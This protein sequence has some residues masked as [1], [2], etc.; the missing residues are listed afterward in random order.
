MTAITVAATTVIAGSTQ[1]SDIVTRAL[2]RLQAIDIN[3]TPSAS[4]QSNALTALQEMLNAFDPMGVSSD[5]FTR[6]CVITDDS[7]IIEITAEAD[8]KRPT[9]PI[10]I[11]HN[12]SGTGIPSSSYVVEVQGPTLFRINADATADGAAVTVTFALLPFAEKFRGAITAM[13]AMRLAPDM[14][15]PDAPAQVIREATE[16]WDALLAAYFPNRYSE[17]EKAI[18]QRTYESFDGTALP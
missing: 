4:E 18:S 7:A 2:R 14:G 10:V 11:G 12:V 6:T 3:E 17:F 15:L 16:G 9:A 13:L 5:S 1:A 8:E